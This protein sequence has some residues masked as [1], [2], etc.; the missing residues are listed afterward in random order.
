M[1]YFAKILFNNV[2]INSANTASTSTQ[3]DLGEAV[4]V[5]HHV[6]P[7]GINSV[8]DVSLQFQVSNDAIEKPATNSTW[9]N[10]DSA[11]IIS[12]SAGTS[13]FM[14]HVDLGAQKGR[15]IVT[16]NSGATVINVRSVG[17]PT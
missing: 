14:K 12:G 10:Q 5:W 16:R 4:R 11:N 15:L 8:S 3:F 2:T 7:T 13:I 17:K 9:L 6:I 1:K